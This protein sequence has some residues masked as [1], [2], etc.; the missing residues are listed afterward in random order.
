MVGV[1]MLII[2]RCRT[3]DMLYPYLPGAHVVLCSYYNHAL[4]MLKSY[5]SHTVV[6]LLRLRQRLRL[7][8]RLRLRFLYYDCVILCSFMC[9]CFTNQLLIWHWDQRWCLYLFFS[10]C[11]FDPKCF[12]PNLENYKYE[13]AGFYQMSQNGLQLTIRADG[14]IKDEGGK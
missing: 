8:L 10:N 5:C 11:G 9:S 1:Y 6:V 7:R 3:V 13:E 12:S 14:V 2:C 4:F